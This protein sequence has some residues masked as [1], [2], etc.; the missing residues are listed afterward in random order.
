[1]SASAGGAKLVQLP[2]HSRVP[3]HALLAGEAGKAVRLGD[4]AVVA[5]REQQFQLEAAQANQPYHII[6]AH[7]GA[8][9]FPT[10]DA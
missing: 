5:G 10:G 1:M 3:I 4:V 9:G 7:G 6:E 2:H 8:T